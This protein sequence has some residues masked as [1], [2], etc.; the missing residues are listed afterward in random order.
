MKALVLLLRR[1]S[2]GKPKRR[3]DVSEYEIGVSLA[4]GEVDVDGTRKP[5]TD[6]WV[7]V[8][9]TRSRRCSTQGVCVCDL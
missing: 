2:A 7:A 8:S 3:A 4:K 9:D 5:K 6:D 1:V